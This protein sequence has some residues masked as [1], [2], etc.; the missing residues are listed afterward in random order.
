M[1]DMCAGSRECRTDSDTV[2]ERIIETATRLFASLGYDGTPAQ[3][4]A[5]A[6]GLDV[7]TVTD[8]V[9]NK[10]DIYLAVMERAYLALRASYDSAFAE[11]T[12]DRAGV[13]LL[14]D[15]YLDFCVDN[16]EAPEL[17]IHRWLSDAA[18]VTGLEALYIK[19]LLDR[20]SDALRSVVGPK[21]DLELAWWTVIW[22]VRGFVVG[23]V[24]NPSGQPE[25][26]CNTV[27][28]RRFR[29][30]LHKTVECVFKMDRW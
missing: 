2:R 17:W 27:F 5:D 30:H 9:G 25:G 13:H 21:V 29:T 19:P 18:D 11:F 8:L 22:C 20:L 14:A 6:A 24:L 26:P 1:V 3:M 23:G 16:P 10:C 15:R 4:I 28:L 7:A 12:P